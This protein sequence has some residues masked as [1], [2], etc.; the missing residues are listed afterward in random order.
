MTEADKL[1]AGLLRIRQRFLQN[2]DS[3]ADDI[4]RLLEALGNP[5]TDRP[6]CAEIRSIAHRL[7]GTAKTVGFED[8]GVKSARLENRVEQALA[9]TGVPDVRAVRQDLEDLLDEIEETLR[10][11]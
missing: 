2:L 3:Q 8:I 11:E 6:T 1:Q 4:F 7:N 10:G 5:D 9:A